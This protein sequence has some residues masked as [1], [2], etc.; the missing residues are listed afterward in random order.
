MR[1]RPSAG[2]ELSRAVYSTE[3]SFD[4]QVET[5]MFNKT[6][7]ALSVA[8]VLC[9]ASSAF[10]APVQVA[11]NHPSQYGG[12]DS[13]PNGPFFYVD[14]YGV[15]P[16]AQHRVQQPHRPSRRSTNAR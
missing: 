4:Q 6:R 13:T 8:I 5:T 3:D 15:P 10:A 2:P 16:A 1:I 9:I 7:I 11:D 12:P 14:T